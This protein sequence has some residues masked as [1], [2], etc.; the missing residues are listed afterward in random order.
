[1]SLVKLAIEERLSWEISKTFSAKRI[2]SL[3]YFGTRA[4]DLNTSENSDYDFM[5]ILDKYVAIDNPNLRRIL[6]RKPFKS[7]D[8]NLNLL[9]LSDIKTRGKMNFQLRSLSLTFYEYLESAELLLGKNIFKSSL[10]KLSRRDI[11][12]N[13]DLKIQEYYGR[14]DKLYFQGGSDNALYSHLLKYTKDIVWLLLIREG[15][16]KISELT[17][18][19]YEEMLKLAVA[20]RLMTLRSATD[21]RKLLRQKFSKRNLLGL[22]KIRRILYEKYLALYR[23]NKLT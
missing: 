8:M 12:K 14:C 6:K 19:P 15:I 2:V 11:V 17:T 18:R 3:L 13:Q 5:L 10:I 20:N 22:E 9:Y 7:L 4:F 1:M 23:I 21:L 16:I